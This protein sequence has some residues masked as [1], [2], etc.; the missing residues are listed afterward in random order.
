MKRTFVSVFRR[1]IHRGIVL[2]V[3]LPAAA[4]A[5]PPP[6][7]PPDKA[8][9]QSG[10]MRKHRMRNQHPR[11]E[12]AREMMVSLKIWKLTEALSV[13]ETLAEKLYPRIH[14]L[15]TL[16]YNQGQEFEE[17][18]EALRAAVDP[19]SPDPEAMTRRVREL[20]NIKLRHAAQE[21]EKLDQIL[22]LLTPGQQ[23]HFFLVEAD[24]QDNVRQF[25]RQRPGRMERP[26]RGKRE[27]DRS[28]A[29]P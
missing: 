20:R 25:L 7:N 13:D 22:E 27:R 2:A 15:E 14:E 23:A 17:A 9:E 10:R 8:F 12:K 3:V 29:A 18:V 28:P 1:L 5:Q 21:K 11:R 19:E 4:V 16:R 6:D 26:A 24:F